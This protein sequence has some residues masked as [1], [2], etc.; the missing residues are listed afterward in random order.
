MPEKNIKLITSESVTEGHPDKV[1]DQI[2]DGIYDEMLKIDPNSRSAVETFCTTGLVVVGGEV[3]TTAYVNIEKVVREVLRDIGYDKQEYG[4]CCDDVGV[5]VCIHEQSSD[6]A[7]GV[8]E[9]QGECKEQG[10]G[11]Q[12]LMIGYAT[13]ETPEFMPLPIVLANKLTKKLACARKHGTLPYLRPDGK[14]QVTI[15]YNNNKAI[16]AE[17]VVIAAH[18]SEKVS[19]KKLRADIMKNVIKPVMGKLLDSK[20]KYFINATGKFTFGGPPADTGLTGRKIIVDT[21]GG[22]VPHGGGAFSGK[23]LTKVD[24][25][26]AYMARYV[27]KNVVAAGLADKCL[28]QVAYAIGIARPVGIYID[29]YGT[30]KIS[31]ENILKLINKHF[32][33][34]PKQIIEHLNLKRSIYKKTAAYGH[35]GRNDKDFTWEAVDKVKILKKEAKNWRNLKNIMV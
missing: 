28:L 14:S 13:N 31:E 22:A 35:F 3:T 25:S 30:N 5:M 1:C 10:A 32:D 4:F 19:L 2:S 7:Q 8:N 34:R 26:G 11:D 20:T 23:D 18:H 33:F 17:T 21:Y 15:E 24:R 6:I 16:R 12:G 9:G 27:A 29:T